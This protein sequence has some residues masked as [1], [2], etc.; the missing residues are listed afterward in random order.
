M[1]VKSDRGQGANGIKSQSSFVQKKEPKMPPRLGIAVTQ[2]AN[3]G[4]A[5]KGGD[6][7]ALSDFPDSIHATGGNYREEEVLSLSF[8]GN[9]NDDIRGTINNNWSE[10]N[11]HKGPQH[12]NTVDS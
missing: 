8:D 9:F 10:N 12:D 6:V 1:L 4:K 5:G 11:S 3:F 2:S 7:L